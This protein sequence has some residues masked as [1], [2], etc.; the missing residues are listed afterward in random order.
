MLAISDLPAAVLCFRRPDPRDPLPPSSRSL[1]PRR[2]TFEVM[3]VLSLFVQHDD[4]AAHRGARD[5]SQARDGQMPFPSVL[6]RLTRDHVPYVTVILGLVIGFLFIVWTGLLTVLLSMTA[7]LWADGYAVLVAVLIYGK[8][9]GMQRAR[10]FTNGRFSAIFDWVAVIWS[11]IICVI[12]IKLNPKDVGWGFLGTIVI[13][14]LLYFI[15]IPKSRRGVLRD[16]RPEAEVIEHEST[17]WSDSRPGAN[18]DRLLLGCD[19]GTSAVKTVLM[20][21]GGDL[22]ARANAEHAMHHPRPGW[23]E[24]NPDDWYQGLAHTVGGS[25]AMRRFPLN[26]WRR[27]AW[28]PSA[29]RWYW[30]TSR[31]RRCARRSAGPI[32]VPGPRRERSRIG[33]V[34]AG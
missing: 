32:A 28:S 26:A 13:R 25:S 4:P 29:N 8:Q 22:L 12:L 9:R 1:V 18:E 34:A 33:S 19:V 31:E 20:A 17:A 24:N 27:S 14:L 10:P 11:V 6:C 2:V 5:V 16:V 23:A 21:A 15:L 3:A 30:S 7:I